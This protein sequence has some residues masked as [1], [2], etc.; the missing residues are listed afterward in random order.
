M[1]VKDEEKHLPHCLRSVSG[2]GAEV[3][4]V[5]TGSKD[6]TVDIARSFGAKIFHFPWTNNFSEARNVSLQHA[7]RD[8]ILWLDADDL[9][10]ESEHAKLRKL[11]A[12]KPERAFHFILKNRGIDDSQCYQLRMFPN[13]P[14]IR[15]E[16][17]IH[18]QVAQSV[19]RLN[20]PTEN[21]DV[22]VV[23][24]GYSSEAV[25]RAKK[26]KYL[27]MMADWLTDHPHDC[28]I[29]YQ[30]ALTNHTLDRHEKAVQAFEK[31]LLKQDCLNQDRNVAFYATV[32][33]GRSYLNLGQLDK[34][35][36]YLLEAQKL[37]SESDFLKISLAEVYTN[38]GEAEKALRSLWAVGD[39]DHPKITFMPMDFRVL[40]FG[41][42]ILLA[43]NLT[44]LGR[45]AE[46]EK[47]LKKA[48]EMWPE[49]AELAHAWGKWF[50]KKDRLLDAKRAFE[51][52]TRLEPESFL[53]HFEKATLS[54]RLGE[55]R[56]AKRSYEVCQKLIP[57]KKEVLLNLGILERIY[58]RFEVSLSY[59]Q[60]ARRLYGE[61]SEVLFQLGFTLLDWG[62][63]TEAAE[64]LEEKPAN[65]SEKLDLLRLLV[66]LEKGD[67]PA[68]E[69]ELE[70]FLSRSGRSG[71]F[72][73][74][75]V[76]AGFQA[77]AEFYVKES[78]FLEAELALRLFEKAAPEAFR[79]STEHL[80]DVQMQAF[81]LNGAIATLEKLL[82]Q[83]GQASDRIRYFQKLG[84]CYRAL[85][86]EQAVGLCEQQIRILQS[87]T[88]QPSPVS[89]PV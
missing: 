72:P 16:G 50:E 62:R 79:N 51:T 61:N 83:P 82:I 28:L 75:G 1:I 11:S 52:A 44:R 86:V 76:G 73:A 26:E 67:V 64:I 71:Y 45:L 36:H 56:E 27:H 10:P 13:H 47:H 22:V 3:I 35:L 18:E 60:R 40:R 5:D 58:G 14:A 24:T 53:Y 48:E 17:A 77:L 78:R 33:T 54:L 38:R 70:V 23:H 55:A 80:A 30:F 43:T 2:L 37:Q 42:E 46:A 4:V 12:E 81:H 19:R 84:K 88:T 9:L 25:V 87:A 39:L 89:V 66:L 32:L 85:G 29:E 8:W 6:R 31:F 49:R 65:S 21:K 68:F 41:R 63:L 59:L 57:D 15:F 20:F 34:A 74:Q 7:S 69:K